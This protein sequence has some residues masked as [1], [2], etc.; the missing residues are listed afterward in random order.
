MKTKFLLVISVLLCLCILTS[1][2]DNGGTNEPQTQSGEQQTQ[3]EA[4]QTNK[5]TPDATEKPDT[6]ISPYVTKY[7]RYELRAAEDD[8]YIVFIRYRE[9]STKVAEFTGAFAYP[10]DKPNIEE[11]IASDDSTIKQIESLGIETAKVV[12]SRLS[13]AVNGNFEFVE[14]DTQGNDACINIAAQY[15]SMP[16]ESDFSF[17]IQ[18]CENTLI[19]LGFELV[20]NN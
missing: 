4:D 11:F 17:N 1:C 16:I 14:L 12:Y 5:Q 20:D 3:N 7:K 18:N 2:T 13:S 6:Q 8:Y 9:G 15:L 19:E 10:N